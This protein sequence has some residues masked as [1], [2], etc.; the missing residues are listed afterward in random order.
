MQLFSSLG[1]YQNYVEN[2]KTIA[3]KKVIEIAVLAEIAP[4]AIKI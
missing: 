1:F 3:K 4:N 2:V